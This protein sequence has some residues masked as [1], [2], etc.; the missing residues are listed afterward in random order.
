[1]LV[2]AATEVRLLTLKPHSKLQG[3]PGARDGA[4]GHRGLPVSRMGVTAG[5]APLDRGQAGDD[6]LP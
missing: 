5:D 2:E 3:V 6:R 4:G 1:M